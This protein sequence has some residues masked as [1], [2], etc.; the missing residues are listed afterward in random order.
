MELVLG[1]AARQQSRQLRGDVDQ[2]LELL[3]PKQ[4]LGDIDRDDSLGAHL[5]S[6]PDRKVHDDAAVDEQASVDLDGGHGSRHGHARPDGA[7][8]IATV[9]HNG[10]TG[11]E[12]AGHGT[13]RDRQRVEIGNCGNR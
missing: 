10:L 13:E 3:A 11:G 1:T 6:H 4:L 5:V 7:T 8:E 9:E 2:R 12:L